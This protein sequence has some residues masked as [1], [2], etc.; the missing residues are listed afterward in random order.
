MGGGGVP[1]KFLLGQRIL[2]FGSVGLPDV[3]SLGFEFGGF[4]TSGV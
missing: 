2:K 3:L 4:A 1:R